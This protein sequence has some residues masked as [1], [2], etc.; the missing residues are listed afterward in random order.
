MEIKTCVSHEY[1]DEYLNESNKEDKTIV[2]IDTLRAT[3]TMITAMKNGAKSLKIA[4][5]VEDALRIK[6]ENP[7]MNYIL[8]G[9]RKGL[10][11]KDFDLTNSPLEYTKEMV[12]LKNILMSTSNGTKTMMKIGNDKEILIAGLINHSAVAKEIIKRGKD[13]LIINS[14]TMGKLS[15]EDFITGGAIA[16]EIKDANYCDT[17]IASILAYE[18]KEKNQ[19]IAKGLH[20]RRMV[21]LEYY[22]DLKYCMSENI[23]NIV[24]IMENFIIERVVENN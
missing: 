4:L 16:S 1:I 6:N 23:T 22:D 11:L 20:Y 19:L 18:N 8:G 24:P 13:V 15:I 5:E 9:E 7:E 12:N 21:E 17:T 2:V 3:S 10:R 14:G